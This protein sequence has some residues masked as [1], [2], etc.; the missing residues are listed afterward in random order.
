MIPTA[1]LSAV[2]AAGG[3]VMLL[4]PDAVCRLYGQPPTSGARAVV[5]VLGGRHV[6]QAA[7]TLARPDRLTVG[8]GAL[9]DLGHAAS[10][11]LWAALAR[12]HR[13]PGLTSAS[14]ATLLAVAAGRVL[15]D[16]PR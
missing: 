1:A 10:A 13:R 2:R 12:E 3:T 4:A 16:L 7:V 9:V 11:V 8:G 14:A 5:R 6:V 15:R